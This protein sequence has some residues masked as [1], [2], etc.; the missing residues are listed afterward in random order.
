LKDPNN[1]QKRKRIAQIKKTLAIYGKELAK[2][3]NSSNT[4]FVVVKPSLLRE[5][6]ILQNDYKN[7]PKDVP[8]HKLVEEMFSMYDKTMDRFY[9]YGV[10]T[11]KG[12]FQVT[13]FDPEFGKTKFLD[14]H[15]INN[16]EPKVKLT[17][18]GEYILKKD[19]CVHCWSEWVKEHLIKNKI[20]ITAINHLEKKSMLIDGF[21]NRLKK[22]ILP[23][24]ISGSERRKVF[25]SHKK[26]R[27]KRK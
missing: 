26:Q 19:G 25:G 10:K 11:L 4:L 13:N 5:A 2:Y 8:A 9:K 14:R 24:V 6:D 3:K 23:H 20:K 18:F 17:S 15:I 12:R 22:G 27:Q 21:V 7:L 16:L 1:L